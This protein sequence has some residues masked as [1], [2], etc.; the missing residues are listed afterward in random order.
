VL[1]EEVARIFERMAHVLAFKGEDRFRVMAYGRA[2]VSIRDLKEDLSSIA[3]A[4]KLEEIPGIGNDLSE[5]I[6]E[7]VATHKIGRYEKE[8]RGIKLGLIELMTVPGLGP[9]TLALLHR[10]L[11]VFWRASD[12]TR[13]SAFS[14][15]AL[16]VDSG[17]P[18]ASPSQSEGG[19]FR[20]RM[21]WGGD[22]FDSFGTSHACS[23]RPPSIPRAVCFRIYT[24]SS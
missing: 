13:T 23:Q 3:K 2:A 8:C 11:R 4:G 24:G 19:R 15:A 10:R 9:K 1:N 20:W 6:A 5:M 21:D 18:S 12:Q 7:F 17:C 16:P 14:R 22:G